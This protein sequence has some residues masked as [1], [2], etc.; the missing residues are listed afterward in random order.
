MASVR[1]L[2]VISSLVIACI[3][4][5]MLAVGVS[6]MERRLDAQLQT[7]SENAAATL[8]LLISAQPDAAARRRVLDA[9]FQQGRFAELALK[10]DEAS[11]PDFQA[12][13]PARSVGD[14]PGWFGALADIQPHQ[15]VRQVAGVGTLRLTLGLE[16]ARDAL[17]SHVMQWTWLALGLAAFWILFIVAL[18]A[19]VRRAL[20][21]AASPHD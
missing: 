7:D 19:R 5:G 15:A 13:R 4:V 9:A 12:R 1:Q 18:G 2:L 20:S 3:L 17:W 16:P 8:A 21:T 14:A 11:A 6:L 10:P